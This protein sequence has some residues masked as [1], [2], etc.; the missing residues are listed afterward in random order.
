MANGTGS[1]LASGC[2]LC[3][4]HSYQFVAL[5]L[6]VAACVVSAFLEFEG[7]CFYVFGGLV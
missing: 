4:G 7:L 6:E 5:Q 1:Q 2:R 3:V